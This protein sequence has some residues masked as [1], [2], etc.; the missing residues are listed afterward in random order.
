MNTLSR[1]SLSG[2]LLALLV[3]SACAPAVA[4]SVAPVAPPA[5]AVLVRAMTTEPAKLDPQGPPNS[6]LSLLLPYL[7]DTLVVRDVDNTILP[8]LASSWEVADDG[9]SITM[10]LY[11]GVT[12]HDGEPLNAAAVQT[13]FERFKAVGTASPIYEGIAQFAAIET[14]D[15]LTVRFVFNEPAAN[16]WSTVS[17]PFAAII[18]PASIAAADAAGGGTLVGSGPFRLEEWQTGQSITLVRNP[19]Y[20]WGP[21]TV[22]NRNAPYLD[23]MVF[24]VI[25]DAATQLAALQTGEVDVL[26]INQPSHKLQLSAN[27]DVTL[28]ETVLNSLIYLGYNCARAPFDEVLV[29]RALSH[30]VNKAEIVTLALGGL[31]QVADAPLPPTLPGYDPSLAEAGQAYDPALAQALLVEAGFTQSADGAWSRDGVRLQ[32][33]LLTST[34]QPNEAIATLLQAQF[35]AIGVPV[36][37]QQ[38]DSRAVMEATSAGEFEFLLWRYD[39]N[40]PDALNIFLSSA[41]IGSTNRVAY[42]NPAVDELLQAGAHTLDPEARAAL[43]VEAQ[44][45]ILAD[46]PWQP[47]YYPVD[48]IAVS[49]RIQGAKPGYM[50]RLL[51]ND[52]KVIGR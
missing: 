46:A 11:P 36:E 16:F 8:A 18:S 13:T 9:L 34:R 40:D 10:T 44:R 5:E 35:A 47:L 38:L 3:L 43:Y 15:D 4:P 20:A 52:A 48:V 14:V 1:R 6:G 45:L 19:D 27:P 28:H 37:I 26:F 25:P 22:T 29:R 42:S 31:G 32:G 39:W 41:R 30:A 17:M 2:L 21:A 23:K 24:K 33:R 50:G 51:V 49:N 12:F 7:Y